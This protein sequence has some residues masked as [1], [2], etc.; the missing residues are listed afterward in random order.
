MGYTVVT[1]NNALINDIQLPIGIGL[2]FE[3]S[4]LF[5]GI[6]QNTTQVLNNL[7]LLLL[8]KHVS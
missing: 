6:Y 8:I 2:N 4:Q 5:D 7:K 3:T 1:S